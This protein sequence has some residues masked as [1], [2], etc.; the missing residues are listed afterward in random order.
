MGLRETNEAQK[1][2]QSLTH[3]GVVAM[4]IIDAQPTTNISNATTKQECCFSVRSTSPL[5]KLSSSSSSMAPDLGS[6]D[7][8]VPMETNSRE[9]V[10]RED[11]NTLQISLT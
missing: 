5:Q 8:V 11:T 7:T 4:P 10:A 9:D 3:N 1:R 6:V 2:R